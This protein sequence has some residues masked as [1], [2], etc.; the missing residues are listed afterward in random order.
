MN[1][2]YVVEVYEIVKYGNDVERNRALRPFLTHILGR[3]AK[4]NDYKMMF[5][6]IK[7]FGH[8][9]V[10][11]SLLDFSYSSVEPE[12]NFWSYVYAICKN[13]LKEST[14]ESSEVLYEETAGLV[15][16]IKTVISNLDT[17]YREQLLEGSL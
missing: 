8:E 15:N 12:G 7:D 17:G 5:R 10:F 6:L 13:K 3:T 4:T 1:S 14:Q 11:Q 9:I 2:G 16:N